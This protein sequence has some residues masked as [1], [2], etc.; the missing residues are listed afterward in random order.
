LLVIWLAIEFVDELVFGVQDS[1][2]PLIRG[3][4]GLSYAAI[5]L[6][7]S[8]PNLA[9]NLIEIPIGLL[10]DSPRRRGFVLAGGALFTAALV[11]VAVAPGFGVLLA[12]LAVLYPASG[13]FVALSQADLMDADTSRREQNMARWNLVGSMGALAGPALLVAAVFVGAGWRGAYA[14]MA[15]VAAVALGGLALTAKRAEAHAGAGERS[16]AVAV[17]AALRALARRDVLRNLL[18]LEVS[19]LMLDVLTGYLALYFVDVLGEP[20]WV[21]ALVVGVRI[22]AGLAGDFLTIQVLERVGGLALVRV[23]AAA[24]LVAYPLFLLVPGVVAKLVALA[25][26]SLLTAGWYPVL[27][28]RLYESLPGQSGAQLAIGNV[29]R[30]AATPIPLLIGLAAARFGL[31]SALWIFA[32]SPILLTALLARRRDQEKP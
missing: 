31:G 11:G 23:T 12:A 2:L 3:D 30:I 32:V 8:A 13:A 24:A 22:A 17:R 15:V 9:A 4:L 19:D 5:G 25:L 16:L 21:G 27:Q 29:F 7:L 1:A 18:L 10:A 20:A 26:L 28:A 6:L 14:A